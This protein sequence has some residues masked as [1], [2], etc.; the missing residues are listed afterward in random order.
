MPNIV[1]LKTM[2]FMPKVV[3]KHTQFCPKMFEN[4]VVLRLSWLLSFPT[5][6]WSLNFIVTQ[7][8]PVSEI[9]SFYFLCTH[10]EYF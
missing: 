8:D 10:V 3:I 6:A 4:N 1:F 5:T 7:T 2:L 9:S